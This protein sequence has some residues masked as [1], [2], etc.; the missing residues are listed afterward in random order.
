MLKAIM[1]Q[2]TK[3][4]FAHLLLLGCAIIL[5][6]RASWAETKA[7]LI[8]AGFGE[9]TYQ[10][11]PTHNGYK[12]CPQKLAL[13]YMPVFDQNHNASF[14]TVFDPLID[15]GS[16]YNGISIISYYSVHEWLGLSTNLRTSSFPSETHI[17]QPATSNSP[18]KVVNQTL[19]GL[20]VGMSLSSMPRPNQHPT[21]LADFTSTNTPTGTIQCNYQRM[22]NIC[23]SLP[24]VAAA[25]PDSVVH[26]P[27]FHNN[28]TLT[29]TVSGPPILTVE[30]DG[31]W[32]LE[33]YDNGQLNYQIS[34]QDLN[35]FNQHRSGVTS[36]Q[37]MSAINGVLVSQRLEGTG[38]VVSKPGG[39]TLILTT[40]TNFMK[41][42]QITP[43]T[44]QEGCSNAY[45]NDGTAF[46]KSCIS[47]VG[48]PLY[49]GSIYGWAILEFPTFSR[50][51]NALSLSSDGLPSPDANKFNRILY[52]FS[53]SYLS[54]S[55]SYVGWNEKNKS[56]PFHSVFA[57]S[58]PILYEF[59]GGP[60]VSEQG[61]V[62]GVLTRRS[63]GIIE[64]SLQN[65]EVINMKYIL[66]TIKDKYPSL[67]NELNI[68]P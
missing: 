37:S 18:A 29:T 7:Q 3:K 59:E 10:I 4:S 57:G 45:I 40:L 62:I 64:M 51:G 61:K 56:L 16:S 5:N 2:R 17:F 35:I 48:G 60:V 50:S 14:A 23:S 9:G 68:V 38:F 19:Q 67:Y 15:G 13:I 25:W 24:K 26:I 32:E 47:A 31:Q 21:L 58:G 53:N 30:H 6:S 39:R 8:A 28:P 34:Q 49:S 54:A 1:K 12:D 65:Y 63:S 36:I 44:L 20:Q 43:A 22:E 42:G 52:H 46:N 33:W 27:V 41:G 11:L 55:K 66:D